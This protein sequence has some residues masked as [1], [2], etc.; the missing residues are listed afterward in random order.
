[1]ILT[2]D[3]IARRIDHS[4]LSPTMTVAE[5]EDGCRLAA[6]YG[7]ASV[8][9]KP[10]AVDLAVK[11]L[12]GTPVNVGTTIG[13][14]HGG[15]ASSIKVLESRRAIDDGATELDMVVNIGQVIGGDWAAVRDDIAGV[16]EMAHAHGAIVKVIFEN[17]YLNDDQK[18][19]LCAICG[20]VSADFVKTSTGYGTGGATKEDI[21][22]MR[23]ESPTHVKV[24]AAGGMRDLDSAIAF[25][26]LG[27][28]R[29]GLSRT[30]DILDALLD[31]LGEPRKARSVPV[32]R[33]TSVAGNASY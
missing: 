2:Y 31:R 4:L 6:D 29:L 28:D 18:A 15:H 19:R 27:C 22:L 26:E 33:G 20:E 24:K 3:A 1:M 21:L 16:T 17:C 7:V 5:L 8:C 13:F 30:A 12:A 11:H 23:R 14:P 25:A 10:F 32:S 9:I